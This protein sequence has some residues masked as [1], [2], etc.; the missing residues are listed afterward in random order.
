MFENLLPRKHDGI[1]RKL[2]FELNTWHS[3]AKLRLHTETT[4][5]DLE[6]STTRLGITLRKFQQDVCS[7]YRTFEL[8][9]EE[10]ARVRRQASA[11]KKDQQSQSTKKKQT[12]PSAMQKKKAALTKLQSPE[13][14]H[15][16]KSRRQ[17]TLNLNTYKTHALG[18][19]ARAIR[20]YGATDNYNSQTVCFHCQHTV[21]MLILTILG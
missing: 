15:Q 21:F 10:A 5:N 12:Q 13:P 6:H 8:P 1:V 11:A 7:A 20:L 4:V 19:Y 9:S 14:N 16:T 18:S 3:L 2:L 17:R